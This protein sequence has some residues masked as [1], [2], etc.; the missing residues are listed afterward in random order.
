[1][2]SAGRILI[3][4]KGDYDASVTYEILDLVHYNETAWLARKT[5]VGVEPSD[6]NGEYWFKFGVINSQEYLST[7]GGKLRGM[8]GVGGG[9]GVVNGNDYGVVLQSFVDDDN[10]RG[11]RVDNPL[12]ATDIEHWLKL[13]DCVDGEINQYK[14]FGEHNKELLK[15]YIEQ[16]IAEYLAKN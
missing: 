4:P 13:V 5:M 9:K 7:A 3:M 6:A 16:I 8:L 1:M 11:I 10:Y 15:P 12:Q 2:A 14:I